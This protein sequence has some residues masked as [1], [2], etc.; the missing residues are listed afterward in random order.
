MY[1]SRLVSVFFCI[2]RCTPGWS[3]PLPSTLITQHSYRSS[4]T[5]SAAALCACPC[6]FVPAPVS[7][8]APAPCSC[9][10]FCP[11]SVPVPALLLP[12]PPSPEVCIM[13]YCTVCYS[14][15][16]YL[17][18]TVW[19]PCTVCI[20]LLYSKVLHLIPLSSPLS[21]KLLC[22]IYIHLPISLYIS[23]FYMWPLPLPPSTSISTSTSTST[24]P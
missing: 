24:H 2:H 10:C 14:R 8:P 16:A 5:S 20:K 6:P 17:H 21:P 7:R 18:A 13:L 11:C 12:L 19:Y 3:M 1:L 23:L 9:P 4:S 15:S 22:Q